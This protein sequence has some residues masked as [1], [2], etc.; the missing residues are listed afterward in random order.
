MN[1]NRQ[2]NVVHLENVTIFQSVH[3]SIAKDLISSCFIWK[4]KENYSAR[5][6]IIVVFQG[7]KK[8]LFVAQDYAMQFNI[9]KK[10]NSQYF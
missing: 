5:T 6:V 8:L 1:I 10:K 2:L 4:K 3:V 7:V 9:D